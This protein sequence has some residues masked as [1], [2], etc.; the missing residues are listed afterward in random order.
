MSALVATMGALVAQAAP[1]KPYDIPNAWNYVFAGWSVVIVALVVYAV[2]M[3][4]KGRQLA[5]QLPPEDRRW[6]S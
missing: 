6:T 2:L 5:R 1:A 3:V 4:R